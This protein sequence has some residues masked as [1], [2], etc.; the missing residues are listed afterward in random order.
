MD[1]RAFVGSVGAMMAA[2]PLSAVVPGV[3]GDASGEPFALDYAPHFGMFRQSS[4]EDVVSQLQWMHDQGF[5]SLED[6]GMRGRSVEEQERI[7]REMSRL[8]MRMGVFVVNPD[9]AFGKVTFASG[10][11]DFRD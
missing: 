7:A 6:N 11:D 1:R 5:R 9:T 3:P 8:G 2:T 10:S 4:G